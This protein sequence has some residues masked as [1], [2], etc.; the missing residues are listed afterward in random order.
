MEERNVKRQRED[1]IVLTSDADDEPSLRRQVSNSGGHSIDLVS[2]SSMSDD[3]DMFHDNLMKALVDDDVQYTGETSGS[4]DNSPNFSA[5]S[6]GTSSIDK[7]KGKEAGSQPILDL[8][9]ELECFICCLS[10]FWLSNYSDVNG[11]SIYMFSMW[12][13]RLRAVQYLPLVSLLI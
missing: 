12:S 3:D 8:Q 9:E 6:S 13:R 4:S 10:V 7:G 5:S 11:C 2:I 1:V